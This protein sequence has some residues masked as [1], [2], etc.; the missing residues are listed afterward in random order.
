MNINEKLESIINSINIPNINI[1]YRLFNYK[2]DSNPE[3]HNIIIF[4]LFTKMIKYQEYLE[5]NKQELFKFKKIINKQKIS[6]EIINSKN[7]CK[8]CL[9]NYLKPLKICGHVSLCERCKHEFKTINLSNESNKSNESNE[10]NESNKSNSINNN[11]CKY[12]NKEYSEIYKI[13]KKK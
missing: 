12:C 5:L 8:L 10:S 9:N 6:K 1:M 7:K 3:S 11:K 13:L 2:I 4:Y